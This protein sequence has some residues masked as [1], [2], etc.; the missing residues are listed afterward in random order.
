MS[1][2]AFIIMLSLSAILAFAFILDVYEPLFVFGWF[3]FK[4]APSYQSKAL[5]DIRSKHKTAKRPLAKTD[6]ATCVCVT[7]LITGYK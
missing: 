4:N 2:F 5:D 1:I 7:E 3:L 6:T